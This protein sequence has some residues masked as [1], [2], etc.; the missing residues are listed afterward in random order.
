MWVKYE[1]AAKFIYQAIEMFKLPS[2]SIKTETVK[3]AGALHLVEDTG[4][5]MKASFT[6]SNGYRMNKAYR[7]G[8]RFRL[9]INNYQ[10]AYVYAIGS[11]LSNKIYQIFPHAKGVSPALNYSQNSVPIPS[12]K[13]HVRMDGNIGTDYLCVIY[14]KGPLNLKDIKTNILQ[15][16]NRYTFQEKVQNV[17]GSKLMS[18]EEINYN[19]S[20]GIMRFD[21]EA[22]GKSIAT[23][24]VEMEHIE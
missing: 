3:L 7:S 19:S 6:Q 20:N 10:P 22:K 11:D 9:Y 24:F 4:Q 21:S 1:D 12:E 16:S 14:S 18:D 23:I 5:E 17:L 15:Q 13:E 8:T 2:V